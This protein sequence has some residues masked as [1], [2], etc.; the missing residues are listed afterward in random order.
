MRVPCFKAMG[1]GAEVK[2]SE[3]AQEEAL[4]LFREFQS[5]RKPTKMKKTAK[6]TTES[7]IK[8]FSL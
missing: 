1:S 4:R 2:V 3:A 8:T 6:F 7:M 5:T